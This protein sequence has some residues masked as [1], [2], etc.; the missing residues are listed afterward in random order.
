MIL[1]SREAILASL[2]SSLPEEVTYQDLKQGLEIPLN[3]RP[4]SEPHSHS[5]DDDDVIS[6]PSAI[7]C[8]FKLDRALVKGSTSSNTSC[9]LSAAVT[10]NVSAGSDQSKITTL[11]TTSNSNHHPSA[12]SL[13][14]DLHYR[15]LFE[16]L[17]VPAALH[18]MVFSPEKDPV[19]GRRTVIDTILKDVNPA[20]CSSFNFSLPFF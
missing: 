15:G 11:N 7:L 3:L 9:S 8:Q 19:T 18:E 1:F 20:F 10:D 16:N 17:Q 6:Q 4:Q 14:S 12:V 2:S 13:D 5:H